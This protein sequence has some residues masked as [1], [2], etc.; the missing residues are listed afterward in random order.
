[1]LRCHCVATRGGYAL[2]CCYCALCPC[3]ACS[4]KGEVNTWN[5]VGGA[6]MAASFRTLRTIVNATWAGAARTPLIVGPDTEIT[7]DKRALVHVRLPR[8]QP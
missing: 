2:P 3:C 8:A 7:G 1:M 6:D 5:Q 4:G